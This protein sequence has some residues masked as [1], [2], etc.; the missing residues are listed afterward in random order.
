MGD[1]WLVWFSEFISECFQV[2]PNAIAA[3][4]R[5]ATRQEAERTA[6]V[7]AV[8]ANAEVGIEQVSQNPTS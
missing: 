7:E 2:R 8:A 6:S 4:A 1:M 5:E 3:T